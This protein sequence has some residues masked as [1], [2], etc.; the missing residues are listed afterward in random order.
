M[1]VSKSVCEQS[2]IRRYGE[3]S[4]KEV[5]RYVFVV[6]GVGLIVAEQPFWQLHDQMMTAKY[7]IIGQI[8][9]RLNTAPHQQQVIHECL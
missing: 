5:T 9:S 8:S 7:Q 2:S 6:C 1:C 3:E 4:R